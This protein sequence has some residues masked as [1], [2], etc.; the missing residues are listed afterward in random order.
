VD[1]VY[2]IGLQD[3]KI[4]GGV[5]NDTLVD[6]I[7]HHLQQT[8]WREFTLGLDVVDVTS[9]HDTLSNLGE[10]PSVNICF[11]VFFQTLERRSHP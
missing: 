4:R 2:Y 8:S 11:P 1:K 5:Y 7:Y 9:S 10:H 6:I 3:Y